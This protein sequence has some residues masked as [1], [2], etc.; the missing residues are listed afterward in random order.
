MKQFRISSAIGAAALIFYIWLG[1]EVMANR[2]LGF[3][4]AVRNAVH[5]WASGP[6]TGLMLGI[7]QMGAPWVLIAVTLLMGWWFSMEGR[8]RAAA[9][10]ALSTIGA[11]AT[12]EG[13]KTL[14]HRVRPAAFFGYDEPMTYSFP[15][16]HATTSLCFYGLLA[17]IVTRWISSAGWQ[18][19][20]WAVSAFLISL[21]GLSRVYLGVHYPTDVLGGY[22]LGT[23]WTTGVIRLAPLPAGKQSRPS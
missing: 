16:G 17:L 9:V 7:T 12:E 10:L 4:T 11:A 8:K 2:T 6:L 21:I 5:A 23:V 19:A 13:L 1:R 14:Y 22:A 15:S 18:R 3:D 20:V